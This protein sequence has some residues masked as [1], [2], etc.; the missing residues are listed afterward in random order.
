MAKRT[1]NTKAGALIQGR[2]EFK[3]SNMQGVKG[4]PSS[5]GWLSGTQFSKQLAD[6]A[7]TTDYHIKSYNTPIAVHHEGGWLY[8]D[9]SHSPST[10]RHQSIVRQAIGVKSERDKTMERRAAKRKAKADTTESN[11]WNS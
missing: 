10:G 8:P 4:A 5:H 9:V 7:N 1:S 2:E 11:L 6:V 3:G